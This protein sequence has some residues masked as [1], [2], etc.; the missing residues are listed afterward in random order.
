[1]SDR[2]KMTLTDCV[3]VTAHENGHAMQ[4]LALI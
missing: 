4:F 3:T 1:L 2:E